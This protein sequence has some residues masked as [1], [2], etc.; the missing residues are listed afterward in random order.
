MVDI[1]DVYKSVDINIGTV[2]KNAE[3]LKFVPEHLK[4]KKICKYAVKTLSIKICITLS[5]KICS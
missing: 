3:M 2:M 1:M 4:S 5:I